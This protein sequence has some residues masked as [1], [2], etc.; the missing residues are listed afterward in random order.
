MVWAFIEMWAFV[1]WAR[2]ENLVAW[3]AAALLGLVSVE[4]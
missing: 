1:I 3:R 4:S 2:W